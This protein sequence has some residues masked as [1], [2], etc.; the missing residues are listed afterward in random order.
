MLAQ[1]LPPSVET[2]RLVPVSAAMALSAVTLRRSDLEALEFTP[3]NTEALRAVAGIG[4]AGPEPR[5]ALPATGLY[6]NFAWG[7]GPY[8][9]PSYFDPDRPI[10]MDVGVEL[11][12]G[13]EPAPGWLIRFGAATLLDTDPELVLFGRSIAPKRLAEEG[14]D[15][16]FPT[17][18]GALADLLG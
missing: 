9:E 2:F 18:D 11:A 16:A 17:L 10:R 7:V 14:Y 1:V 12:M 6:P 8:F 13:Y 3:D 15:F 5:G 4:E